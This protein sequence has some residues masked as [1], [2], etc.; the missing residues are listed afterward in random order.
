MTHDDLDPGFL[1]WSMHRR[2]DTARMPP[3]RTVIELEFTGAPKD[4]R[5]FWLVT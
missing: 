5:R 1:A 3:G 4:C 2:I